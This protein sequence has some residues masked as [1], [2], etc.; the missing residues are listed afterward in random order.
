MNRAILVMKGMAMGFAD[1]IPGVSGGTLALITGI[2]VSFLEA[3]KSLNINW[4]PPLFAWAFSGFKAEKRHVFFEAFLTIHWGFLIP[5][6]VGIVL[7]FGLG[8][9]IVPELMM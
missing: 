9:V 2:Y 1:V 8:S 4:I 6:G 3:I 7:A 5:L